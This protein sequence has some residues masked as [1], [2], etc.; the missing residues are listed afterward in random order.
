MSVMIPVNIWGSFVRFAASRWR[1]GF[2]PWLRRPAPFA[3]HPG[4]D[5]LPLRHAKAGFYLVTNSP[6]SRDFLPQR[7]TIAGF[8]RGAAAGIARQA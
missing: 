1:R 2:H 7:K 5:A 6:A 4:P 8:S 3:K